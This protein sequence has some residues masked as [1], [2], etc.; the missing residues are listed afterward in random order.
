MLPKQCF[1]SGKWQPWRRQVHVAMISV[2]YVRQTQACMLLVTSLPVSLDSTLPTADREHF[3][4]M[5]CQQCVVNLCSWQK[6]GDENFYNN[7]ERIHREFHPQRLRTIPKLST[8]STTTTGRKR[9]GALKMSVIRL[10]LFL[11]ES[12]AVTVL[13]T[14]KYM[15]LLML[16]I[17][18]V[19]RWQHIAEWHVPRLFHVNSRRQTVTCCLTRRDS[20]NMFWSW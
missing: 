11:L 19:T 10:E 15:A 4:Y 17:T 3:K 1:L 20:T 18:A 7:T 14:W 2:F 5:T 16:L 13:V 9:L 12:E 6:T 8:P